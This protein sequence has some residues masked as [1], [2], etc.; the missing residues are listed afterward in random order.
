[1]SEVKGLSSI[2]NSKNTVNNTSKS[3]LES[4]SDFSSYLGESKSMDEIFDQAAAKY[5]V[6][7]ELL[8]AIG[9][10]ESGFDANAVSRCGA[11]GVMQLMPATAK[12]LGVTDAFDPEQNIN[13]GAKYISGLLKKYDGDTRL[14]LAAYNA[15]SGNVAKYGGIPPFEET[16]NYVKKVMKYMGQGDIQAASTVDGTTKSANT[17]I[18]H[19]APISPATPVYNN[20][21][22]LLSD[23]TTGNGLEDLGILFSYDDYMNFIDIFLKDEKE[24]DSEQENSSYSSQAINYS[25]PVLNLFKDQ[26]IS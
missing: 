6:P 17:P 11:Q 10:A 3:N 18:I 25:A 9:K 13:G 8:K 15:G 1:M 19:I 26:I 5:N 4:A 23:N 7:V 21:A 12:G 16:Q 20:T 22:Y 14:A 24:K 2:D